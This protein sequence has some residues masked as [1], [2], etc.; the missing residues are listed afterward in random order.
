[1]E[2]GARFYWYLP[3]NHGSIRGKAIG[4]AVAD[5]PTG[6]FTDGRGSALITNDMTTQWKPHSWD[7]IDPAVFFDHDGQARLFWGNGQCY[8][9]KLK[10]NMIELDGAIQALDLPGFE[11][12]PFIHYRK[13]WYYLSYA[14]GA[15]EKIA[16]AMSR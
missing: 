8:F 10:P 6:P 7:D 3:M 2:R 1:M 16:Y 12:A 4:V 5:H 9:A 15:P 14:S 11:E 13:G